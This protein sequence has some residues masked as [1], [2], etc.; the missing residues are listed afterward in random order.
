[1]KVF[2]FRLLW[3]SLKNILGGNFKQAT[4]DQE[5]GFFDLSRAFFSY[6]LRCLGLLGND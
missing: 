4:D 6:V 2:I 3:I 5:S 1:M